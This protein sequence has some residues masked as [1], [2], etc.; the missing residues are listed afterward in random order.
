MS[1]HSAADVV[2]TT[3]AA[4]T[5]AEIVVGMK[6]VIMVLV[7]AAAVTSVRNAQIPVTL[8][9]RLHK[10]DLPGGRTITCLVQ[11]VHARIGITNGLTEEINLQTEAINGLT[12]EINLL[13]EV[14]NG[15]IEEGVLK[16]DN[17]HSLV[18]VT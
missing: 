16:E 8:M 7:V 14:T 1:V 12:E 6:A 11:V 3:K 2:K 9:A 13:T 5:A 15:L 18:M 10:A 17:I 4:N